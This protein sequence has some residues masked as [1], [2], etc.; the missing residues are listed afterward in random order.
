MG[1]EKKDKDKKDKDK[2]NKDKKNKNK[3]KNVDDEAEDSGKSVSGGYMYVCSKHRPL[4][5]TICD[6]GDEADDTC[7]YEGQECGKKGK[8][9]CWFA[10]CDGD[11]DE[12]ASE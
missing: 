10:A 1:K 6:D 12:E 7:S 5:E 4:D 2:K 3:V 8:N 9:T 11:G